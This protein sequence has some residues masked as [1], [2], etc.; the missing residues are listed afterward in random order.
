[1]SLQRGYHQ[2]GCYSK[3]FWLPTLFLERR[4][5][6]ILPGMS[7]VKLLGLISISLLC[8]A[9]FAAF[10]LDRFSRTSAEEVPR[11]VSELDSP[12]AP[13]RIEAAKKLWKVGDPEAL[14]AISERL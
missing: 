8:C 11:L 12:E 5:H 7:L 13:V 1:L 2:A 6:A 10:A 4:L 14:G 9:A 3:L